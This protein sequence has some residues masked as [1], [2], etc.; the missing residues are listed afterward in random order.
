MSQLN[1]INQKELDYLMNKEYEFDYPSLINSINT[2]RFTIKDL[3]VTARDATYWDSKDILPKLKTKNTTRRKYTLTQAIWIKLIKQLREFDISISQ[4]KKFK[5]SIM[6]E[7]LSTIEALSNDQISQIIKEIVSKNGQLEEY[8]KLAKDPEFLKSIQN[9][10]LKLF[11]LAILMT[12]VFRYDISYLGGQDGTCIPYSFEKHQLY[13]ETYPEFPALMKTPHIVISISQAYSELVEDWSEKS[14]F[15]HISILSK[16]ELKIL[17]LL[18]DEN[19]VELKIFKK[20]KIPERVIQVS[21]NNAL[22]IKD[23]ANFITINGY[24][25]ITISTRQGKIVNFK[26]EVSHKLNS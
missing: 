23:F 12:I 26:N 6:D 3:G 9:E 14:W 4:I 19:T 18:R 13:M 17:E 5:D 20:D 24:Q 8:E 16:E 15:N 2:P 21:K 25:T 22:A 11:E 1:F 7:E 10:S